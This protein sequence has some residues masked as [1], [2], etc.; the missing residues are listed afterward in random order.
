MS[1]PNGPPPP[2][3]PAGGPLPGPQPYGVPPPP[4]AP[5]PPYGASPYGSPPGTPAYGYVPPV[6]PPVE[7]GTN[8]LAIASLVLSLLWLCGLGSLLAV[9][10]G[11]VAL[12]QLK[13]L[14]G[15]G[16]GL[17]IAGIV[18]GFVGFAA[19]ALGGV[20]IA[21]SADDIVTT[22]PDEFNDV[23]ITACSVG[24]GGVVRIA[25]DVT[26]DSSKRSSY[27]ITVGVLDQSTDTRSTVGGSAGPVEPGATEHTEL[28]T[29]AGVHYSRPRC[30]VDFVQ[31]FATPG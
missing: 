22:H 9:I 2:P 26:N 12:G 7:R 30:T 4:Y 31:R 15:K 14:G 10:F 23:E 5:P 1:D 24:D 20:L 13:R 21:R 27:L 11:F 16:R 18:V 19:V 3:P 28:A 25:L 29:D 17:A 8:G 6:G